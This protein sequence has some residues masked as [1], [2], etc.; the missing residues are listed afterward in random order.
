MNLDLF[1]TILELTGMPSVAREATG[2]AV[3]VLHPE[4]DRPLIS[5]YLVPYRPRLD[6][7]GSLQDFAR[8][9]GALCWNLGKVIPRKDLPLIYTTFVP[10]EN[11]PAP[12]LPVGD[13]EKAR[14][15]LV[16]E[17]KRAPA[18]RVDN[19]LTQLQD[20]A[21]RLRVHARVADG[22]V[23]ELRRFRFRLW[24]F[25]V[26][27]LA[28]GAL[29]GVISIAAGGQWWVSA[30]LFAAT[31]LIGYGGHHLLRVLVKSQEKQVAAGLPLIFEQ[32]YGR[33]LLVGERAEDLRSIWETVHPRTRHTLEKLGILSF[34][35]LK[36]QELEGLNRVIETQIPEMR[37]KL[38]RTLGNSGS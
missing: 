11:A 25:L 13:F 18:R 3:S 34:R 35:K 4:E 1:P 26:M 10:V 16:R 38:H 5:E 20:H 7:F 30:L 8:A 9:Y 23:R 19:M 22:A 15:E 2:R 24:E 33:E 17:V 12:A 21:E 14:A 36:S 29:A 37:S 31:A 27:V 6:R 32:I 28:L